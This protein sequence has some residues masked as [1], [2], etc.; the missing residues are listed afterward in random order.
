[1]LFD[2]NTPT[3]S[4]AGSVAN[5][6]SAFFNGLAK[7]EP[8]PGAF[9]RNVGYTSK[10]GLLLKWV[11]VFGCLAMGAFV[12]YLTHSN[13][14]TA[15][16][17]HEKPAD[18]VAG[19]SSID[20]QAMKSRTNADTSPRVNKPSSV[21]RPRSGRGVGEFL[22]E[23]ESPAWISE[24]DEATDSDFNFM[25]SDEAQFL[26]PI[27]NAQEELWRAGLSDTEGELKYLLNAIQAVESSHH[28]IPQALRLG[29]QDG[30]NDWEVYTDAVVTNFL[31]TDSTLI[32]PKSLWQVIDQET[33]LVQQRSALPPP[34]DIDQDTGLVQRRSF[35]TPPGGNRKFAPGRAGSF[36]ATMELNR[37]PLNQKSLEQMRRIYRTLRFSGLVENSDRLSDVDRLQLDGVT[38][39]LQTTNDPR[40]LDEV[41][42]ARWIARMPMKALQQA[43]QESASSWNPV[44]PGFDMEPRVGV[45]GKRQTVSEKRIVKIDAVVQFYLNADGHIYRQFFSEIDVLID[46]K[47]IDSKK[48]AKFLDVVAKL[49]V[50]R[51]PSAN[52]LPF[53]W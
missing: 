28:N 15:G 50:P 35:A 27:F 25:G 2:P 42:V 5:G 36:P 16:A 43:T 49:P 19:G 37:K 13:H 48:L 23:A 3:G 10:V 21:N 53:S 7:I 14:V 45:S 44:L 11:F 46:D 29:G 47:L 32:N 4:V 8:Y 39:S 9:T 24:L 38:V 22:N 12:A 52:R 20:M 51:L 18:L 30:A 6:E 17:S 26:K 34:F 1:M 41:V 33:G 31:L 40:S